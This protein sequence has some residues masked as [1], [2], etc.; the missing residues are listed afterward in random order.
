MKLIK[1]KKVAYIETPP[2]IITHWTKEELEEFWKLKK[3]ISDY[4]FSGI[5]WE[6]GKKYWVYV[7]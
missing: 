3:K 4:H 2:E 5:G 7:K 6:G 1:K